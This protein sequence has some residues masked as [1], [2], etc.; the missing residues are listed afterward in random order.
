MATSLPEIATSIAAVRLGNLNMALGN[1]FGSNMFNIFV[2]PF[3]KLISW[4]RGDAYL[5]AG[6]RVSSEQ[7]VITGLIAILLT[8]IAVG[9]LTYKSRRTM[10]R[11][12]GFDSILIAITYL[13][14][15]WLLLAGGK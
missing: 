3:L 4:A 14:G 13:G 10:L 5:V 15:M 8:A 12:F 9:G 2:I 1:I 6:S 11:R 7:I